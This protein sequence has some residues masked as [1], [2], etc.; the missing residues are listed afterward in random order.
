M[1]IALF[2]LPEEI[3][4]IA[5]KGFLHSI[6]DMRVLQAA[7]RVDLTWTHKVWVVT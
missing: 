4:L 7:V 6:L 2:L 3:F 5:G 1:F